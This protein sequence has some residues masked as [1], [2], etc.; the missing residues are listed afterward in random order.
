[1]ITKVLVEGLGGICP[2]SLALF[3]NSY[4]SPADSVSIF[5]PFHFMAWNEMDA[6]D[7]LLFYGHGGCQGPGIIF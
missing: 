5:L 4:N 1:M 3:Y 7:I 6:S 2:K